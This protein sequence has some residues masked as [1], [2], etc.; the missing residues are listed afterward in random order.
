M[1]RIRRHEV[2]TVLLAIV[3][4]LAFV[5]YS[6]SAEAS[7]TPQTIR[8]TVEVSTTVDLRWK[9]LTNNMVLEAV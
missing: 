5:G 3:G 6:I 4:L 9:P 7:L 2:T 8:G 1:K